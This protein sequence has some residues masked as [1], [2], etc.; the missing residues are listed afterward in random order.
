MM[1]P[2]MTLND[3]TEITYSDIKKIDGKEYIKV[4]I[5]RPTENGFDTA[6]CLIPD[7][8]TWK[9]DGF[10]QNDIDNLKQ[11]VSKGAHLFFKFARKGGTKDFA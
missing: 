10:N 6:E 8:D 1:Y 7:Y 5:E 2:Y 9:F 3:E 4:Y 11:I